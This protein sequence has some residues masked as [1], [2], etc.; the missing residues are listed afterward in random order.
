MKTYSNQFMSFEAID[1]QDASYYHLLT[2]LVSQYKNKTINR[3]TFQDKVS[4]SVKKRFGFNVKFEV[5]AVNEINAYMV[6]VELDPAN[7]LTTRRFRDLGELVLNQIKALT[8]RDN[9]KIMRQIVKG[10]LSAT[11]WLDY[12]KARAGGLF[13]Q[14]PPA[15]SVC[16]QGTID[17]LTPDETASIIL[18]ELGHYW[19]YL[20]WLGI[21]TCRNAVIVNAVNE[22]ITA[23]TETEKFQIVLD[24]KNVWGLRVEESDVAKLNDENATKILAGSFNHVFKHT[25]GFVQYDDNVSEVI[26]DQFAIRMGAGKASASGMYKLGYKYGVTDESKLAN[27]F[28]KS[29][30]LLSAVGAI[31]GLGAAAIFPALAPVLSAIGAFIAITGVSYVW[32]GLFGF[33]GM[34]NGAAYDTMKNRIERMYREEIQRLKQTNASIEVT[35]SILAGLEEMKKYVD[36]CGEAN[37]SWGASIIRYFSSSFREQEQKKEYQ[38]LIEEMLANQ[39]YITANKFKTLGG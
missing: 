16:Y 22:F 34:L 3:K 5:H 29:G 4:E 39:L 24:K 32:Q 28:V 17:N 38:S 36:L 33:T 23:K 37:K 19:T 21:Y 9:A 31:I 15:L 35:R 8:L 30:L 14:L 20:E 26:A 27:K 1:F 2:E 13:S 25:V 18:H 7:V 12:K 11:G 10:D 6:P